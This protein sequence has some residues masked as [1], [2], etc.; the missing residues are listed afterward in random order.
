LFRQTD[1][2]TWPPVVTAVAAA[3]SQLP[4]G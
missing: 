3:L 4:V 2:R 1:D